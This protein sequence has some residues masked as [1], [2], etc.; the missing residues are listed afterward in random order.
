M[1]PRS[2]TPGAQGMRI[3]SVKFFCAVPLIKSRRVETG[4][5]WLQG[6]AE[7]RGGGGGGK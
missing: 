2:P 5:G 6:D 4:R 1:R 3:K 7:G